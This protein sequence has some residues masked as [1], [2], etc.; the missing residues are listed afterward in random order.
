MT[1]ADGL[2]A[3]VA[4]A[5][6][7][8]TRPL[9]AL[10]HDGTLSHIA[11]RPEAA[12]LA[13]G[14]SVALTRLAAHAELVI[15]SGRGLDDLQRRFARHPLTL[16]SEHGLRCRHPDG[17]TEQLTTGLAPGVLE[18]L[19]SRLREQLDGQP[20]WLIE[21]K[22]VSIAVHY[23]LVADDELHPRLD[24][25]RAI[26][27][28][29]ADGGG[30]HVQVGRSVLELRPAGADKGSALRWL[31]ARSRARP[32]VMLGDDATDE[33]ALQAAEELG[34]VGVRVTTSSDATAA[35]A[36][37]HGPDDVVTFLDLLATRLER[38]SNR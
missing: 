12:V 2:A 9:I 21:D 34:G 5:V 19:R 1:S 29:T 27:S 16:V 28:E 31:A 37:L 30:G 18:R 20:G 14:A 7:A 35:S 4:A 10:D 32:V 22:G 24:Q 36:R 11:P 38:R 17:T 13:D 8:D 33:P 3:R 23:R 26:L 6:T 15:V 25:V